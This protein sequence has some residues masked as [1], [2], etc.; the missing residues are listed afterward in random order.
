[1]SIPQFL[2][3]TLVYVACKTENSTENFISMQT[4]HNFDSD[5][6][7]ETAY[8]EIKKEVIVKGIFDNWNL[9][10]FL[11]KEKL[12][13]KLTKLNT[14]CTGGVKFIWYSGINL[15]KIDSIHLELSDTIGVSEY[16]N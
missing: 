1:M 2:I 11:G 14:E 8:G 6:L 7:I 3:L 9:G 10:N 15:V 12:T 16:L 5:F 13:T 4:A